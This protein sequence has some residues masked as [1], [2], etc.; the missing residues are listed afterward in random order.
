MEPLSDDTRYSEPPPGPQY[1]PVSVSKFVVLGLVT[2][3]VY[4]IVWFYR[5]WR[6]AKARDGSDIW[7]SVR[8]I[9]NP[10]TYYM[11][12]SDLR[13]RESYEISVVFAL[14]YFLLESL[15][16]LPDPYW[17]ISLLAFLALLPAV[18]AINDLNRGVTPL[19]AC[20]SWR[21]RNVPIVLLGGLF[22]VIVVGSSTGYFP[23]TRVV[24]GSE[25][26]V[27]DLAFLERSGLVPADDEVLYFYSTG[28]FSIQSEGTA[29]TDQRVVS[30]WLDPI[31]YE[32]M[33]DSALFSEIEEVEINWGGGLEDTMGRVTTVD[34]T[35][36]WFV[37]SAEEG[38]DR[39]FVE[40]LDRR[41][42]AAGA[43]PTV[44]IPTTY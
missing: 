22:L 18:Q 44:Q 29:L 16:R 35:S 13:E 20:A 28:I 7:P 24:Q 23:S 31:S 39:E 25:M 12:L 9:F 10:I 1:A 27:R 37:L 42:T 14:A 2:W 26:S 19:P 32:P 41:L 33:T 15:W 38:G 3:G 6:Y 17:L 43:D 5:C 34:G 36:F 8:A 4:S 21:A 11:L 40:E 30:Y